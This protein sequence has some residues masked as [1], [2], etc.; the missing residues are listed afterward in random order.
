MPMKD[1]DAPPPEAGSTDESVLLARLR[2]AEA[3][4][5]ALQGAARSQESLADQLA[6]AMR[7]AATA[8]QVAVDAIAA[9]GLRAALAASRG[10]GVDGYRWPASD[11][12]RRASP[13]PAADDRTTTTPW[14]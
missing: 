14:S 13:S 2:A 10:G 12:R 4:T 1:Q 9:N 6:V 11:D 7:E 5:E 8:R 3:A